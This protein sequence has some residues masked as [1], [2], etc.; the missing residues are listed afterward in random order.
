MPND[1]SSET[2]AQRDWS[3]LSEEAIIEQE[4]TRARKLLYAVLISISL[5]IVWSALAG[6]DT[7]TRGTGKV[8]PSSQVQIIGS[9]DGG[10]VQQ[11]LVSEGELV[12]QGQLLL[13]LDRT[14]SEA[15]LGENQAELRGLKIR[16]LRLDA[17]ASGLEFLPDPAM[18]RLSPQ[19]F[20]EEL[21]L[22]ETSKEELETL[23]LIAIRQKRQRE[24]ELI[25][26]EAKRDQLVKESSLA[27]N[28]LNVTR[29]LVASGA[30]SQVE[31]FRLEREVNRATGELRQVRAGIRR[32]EAAVQ[33]ATSKIETVRLE[34]LNQTR[35]KL[36]E[37]YTQIAS[38][39]QAG[40]GL[41]DRVN[42]TDVVAP[43]T[44]TIKQL[45]YNT[46]GGVVLPGRDIVELI[47]AD[48]TLLLEVKI[49]PKDIAFLA[50]GQEANVKLT[51][52]DFVVYGGM[53]GVIEQIGADTILDSN[54]EPYYE[55]TV[56]TREVDFGP[57]Q[58]IIPGMTVDV[59]IL[60]GRKTVL[61]Y[62][63]KP[64]LR[65]QQRALSER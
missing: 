57:D 33:E 31:I 15:S 4:P 54:D 47:P 48:D 65:A 20:A 59:D 46:V 39:S 27:R 51:A 64:V 19:V 58:P 50:P 35:E 5:L 9:Q 17:L 63:M 18:V 40:E 6:V 21:E 52:Y 38:R 44:G 10:I 34:F 16:A 60:T 30:A 14:R 56:R 2:R 29:P 43:V 61:S 32:S 7:V 45:H 49:K 11:I 12:E 13:S 37:T 1:Q 55:V 36:A 26:L 53:E 62:L 22:F 24:E 42:Q 23:K 41:S 3:E 8:I 28:E 25:E